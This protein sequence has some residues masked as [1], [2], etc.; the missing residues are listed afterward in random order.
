MPNQTDMPPVTDEHRRQAYASL[1]LA[2][3]YEQAMANDT[4]RRV[5][6]ARAATLRKREWQT[7]NTRIKPR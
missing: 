4:H 1:R 2:G 5:I 7:R 6:E 3:T